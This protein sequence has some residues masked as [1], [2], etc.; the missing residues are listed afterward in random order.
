MFWL[1]VDIIFH[2]SLMVGTGLALG[3]LINES[4]NKAARGKKNGEK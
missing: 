1:I 4:A 2:F 3:Y